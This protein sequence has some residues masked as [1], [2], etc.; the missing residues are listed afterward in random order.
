[1]KVNLDRLNEIEIVLNELFVQGNETGVVANNNINTAMQE[2]FN[3]IKEKNKIYNNVIEKIETANQKNNDEVNI[4]LD[5]MTK[6]EE[7]WK[8]AVALLSVYKSEEK[9]PSIAELKSALKDSI[10]L[11]D[12]VESKA[13]DAALNNNI[14]NIGT[15]EEFIDGVDLKKPEEFIGKGVNLTDF[16]SALFYLKNENGKN[17]LVNTTEY[18]ECIKNNAKLELVE[19]D[20]FKELKKDAVDSL[21]I[22]DEEEVIKVV[23]LMCTSNNLSAYATAGDKIIDSYKNNEK[24]FE[25]DYGYSLIDENGFQKAELVYTDLFTKA[26]MNNLLTKNENNKIVVK[27]TPKI[28]SDKNKIT[29]ITWR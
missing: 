18:D 8:R 3:S 27:K 1:M 15:I 13:T 6:V 20:K 7:A 26:N 25:K 11:E 22:A 10:K 17:I 16:G 21:N 29:R 14:A 12:D 4:L 23:S 24:A 28:V 19:T 9:I 5:Y 2:L